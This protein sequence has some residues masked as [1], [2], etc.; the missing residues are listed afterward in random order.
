MYLGEWI[1]CCKR[2][3]ISYCTR[4]KRYFML[5][6]RFKKLITGMATS[7]VILTWIFE[8]IP[9]VLILRIWKTLDDYCL[10]CDVNH[11]IGWITWYFLDVFI[12]IEKRWWHIAAKYGSILGIGRRFG[13]GNLELRRL[14]SRVGAKTF[15]ASCLIF[16]QVIVSW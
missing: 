6:K 9:F 14:I 8:T 1:A 4:C 3:C 5:F 7:S 15:L 16:L 13:L 10:G 2:I 11:F 12:F